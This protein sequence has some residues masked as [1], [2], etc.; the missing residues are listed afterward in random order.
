MNERRS[1]E[2]IKKDHPKKSP[3]SL[4]M[5]KNG[6]PKKLACSSTAIK[7][8]RPKKL[9]CSSA[10]IKNDRPRKLAH[11]QNQAMFPGTSKKTFKGQI[12]RNRHK[13]TTIL[14]EESS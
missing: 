4:A 1:I 6:R 10:V 11:F 8:G 5:I 3:C 2:V 13:N 12:L 9:A 7:N 14:K